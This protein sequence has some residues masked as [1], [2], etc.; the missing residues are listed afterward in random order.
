MNAMRIRSA[1]SRATWLVLALLLPLLSLAF[2]LEG[3]QPS[4]SH[5]DGQLGLYN[6]ECPLAE[7]SAIH[8]VGPL[9]DPHGV[10]SFTVLVGP[11]IS[12][13]LGWV[14]SPSFRVTEPRAPPLA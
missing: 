1:S 8:A 4:H 12:M 11:I 13:S 10:A 5:D 6:A 9:P 7:L 2:V 14:P 3:S